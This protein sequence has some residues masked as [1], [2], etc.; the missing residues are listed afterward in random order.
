LCKIARRLSRGGILSLV[1]SSSIQMATTSLFV[2]AS[3]TADAK[4]IKREV[5][6]TSSDYYIYYIY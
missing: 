4:R 2:M 5:S 3:V 1:V 6:T